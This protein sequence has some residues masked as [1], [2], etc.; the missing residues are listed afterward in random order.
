M[1]AG[2][3]VL[4]LGNSLKLNEKLL[5]MI[6]IAGMESRMNSSMFMCCLNMAMSLQKNLRNWRPTVRVPPAGMRIY[7][8]EDRGSGFS[9]SIYPYRPTICKEF[10]C[11]RMLINDS[12][13]CDVRGKVIGMNEIRTHDAILELSGRRRL[14]AC[15]TRLNQNTIR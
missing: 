11:Y 1:V 4:V 7:A 12:R 9:L 2:D 15:L 6:I 8:P 13:T 10:L 5:H 14:L 3:A